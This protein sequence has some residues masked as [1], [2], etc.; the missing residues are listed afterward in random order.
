MNAD[1]LREWR[2]RH[3]LTQC[4][5][6]VALDYAESTI[7]NWERGLT[8]PDWCEARACAIDCGQYSNV[9]NIA[10]VAQ[11][12]ARPDQNKG[13]RR[14]SLDETLASRF[15]EKVFP[16]PNTGCWLWG[17][18]IQKNGYGCIGMGMRTESA[19]RVSWILHFGDIPN[20]M[21]VLH[22][23]DF[24]PCVNPNHLEIG[25]HAKNLRDAADRGRHWTGENH[26]LAVLKNDDVVAIRSSPK[27]NKEISIEY[28]LCDSHVSQIRTRKLWK[29]I[30]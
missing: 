3:K 4:Q 18:A 6:A 8:I 30:P 11:T 23:C 29:H 9:L 28:G 17:G 14:R 10:R 22:K 26:P 7:A 2:G 27:T 24:P 25:T 19:H 5:A 21:H 16:D 1:D 12:R 15:E 13:G 20:G